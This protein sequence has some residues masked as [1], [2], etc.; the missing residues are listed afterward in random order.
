MLKRLVLL[1]IALPAVALAADQAQPAGRLVAP[2]PPAQTAAAPAPAPGQ[3]PAVV[4]PASTSATAPAPVDP[5]EC[6][7]GCAK[8]YYL[9]GAGEHT[10][11]CG[12]AWS[13]CAAA[14]ALPDLKPD[15]STA[16]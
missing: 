9:C 12:S 10:D 13:Q 7:L 2:K 16:P 3:T 8:T 1:A 14:C 6:R 4:T 15:I 5:D 11:G